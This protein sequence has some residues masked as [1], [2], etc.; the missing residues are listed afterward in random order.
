MKKTAIIFISALLL[1]CFSLSSFADVV[2]TAPQESTQA[3]TAPQGY[4]DGLVR[5]ADISAPITVCIL[6]V[7]VFIVY[8]IVKIKKANGE[9]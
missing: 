2:T 6:A 9:K 7:S 1:L 4:E 8:G 5:E 3:S